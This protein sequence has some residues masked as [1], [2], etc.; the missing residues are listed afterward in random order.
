MN[1]AFRWA[2]LSLA[3]LPLALRAQISTD[4]C[5]ARA[6][7][8]VVP[9]QLAPHGTWRLTG[10]LGGAAQYRRGATDNQPFRAPGVAG[11]L[12]I[13]RYFRRRFGVG[14]QVGG[15][16]FGLQQQY[17]QVLDVAVGALPIETQRLSISNLYSF[18]VLA[19]PVLSLAL[20]RQLSVTGAV[21]GGLFYLDAPTGGVYE[22]PTSQLLYRVG[23][24][25]G[26][27]WQPGGMG[28]LTVA[29]A[30]S[31]Q[32]RLGAT[33]SVFASP[34]SYA[35]TSSLGQSYAI[36]QVLS[37]YSA[38]LS[39]AVDLRRQAGPELPVVLPTC[40]PPVFASTGPIVYDVAQEELPRFRWL[41]G[42]PV[43]AV[44]EEFVFRLF[45]L[46]DNKLVDERTT[47]ENQLSW[48]PGL[49]L[50]TAAAQYYYTIQAS[51]RDQSNQ[52]CLSPAISGSLQFVKNIRK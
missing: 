6:P 49:K 14:V 29:Y 13:D 23:V 21:R 4:T 9:E 28:A 24:A 47:S 45:S 39:L 25:E 1:N 5:C 16:S 12:A 32:V 18:H 3:L 19:G 41:S 40:Y 33:A 51:R 11:T 46:P 17:E 34:G 31:R 42:A 22:L 2:L 20:G 8:R 15:L 50:P 36:S 38:S 37:G 44:D 30:L 27:R 48:R 35:V 43:Y 26:G 10:T 7:R 52:R